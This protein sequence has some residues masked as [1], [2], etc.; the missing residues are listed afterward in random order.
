MVSSIVGN[1]LMEKGLLTGE[2]FRDI[3]NEQQKVRVKL[4][5]IAV[6]EGLMTQ[7]EADR[8]NQLQAV[9]DRRFGDIAVEKGY[10]TEGQVNSLLKKQG[11][12]YLAFAQA[13]EN[14]QLMTI[15]QLEQILL[16]YRCENN[17]TAS[18]MDALKSDDVDSILP[19]FLPVDS[20]AYYGI[21]GTAVRTLM[22]LVDTGLYPDK[23]Y[24][25]QKTE[26]ENGALQKVE[27]E[28]GFVS[29][30]GGKGNALQFTASVFGQEE[31]TSVDEDAL[32]AIGELLNCI[33][34]LYVSECKDGS[35]LELMPPSFKTGIQG[36]E[37]RKMLV[38]PIHIKNDCVD[39]MIAIG[40][41]IEMK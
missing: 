14:Q 41:E 11:N 9:M 12:A 27:G 21:A 36:F 15:E 16:D 29:A 4:G 20:E 33:N 18:D 19:L 8:V 7:E 10:L 34:G 30:L 2:Q 37:S 39:L 17:F 26:D 6:A 23:A 32:D 31:F 25:M 3:L 5:L 40:D 13:M 24:I 28:K 22:R 35:S 38:L 1:Y